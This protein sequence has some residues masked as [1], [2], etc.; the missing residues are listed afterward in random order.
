M[1]NH[2]AVRSERSGRRRR[3]ACAA[4]VGR[5][6]GKL[7]A[8]TCSAVHVITVTGKGE[9]ESVSLSLPTSEGGKRLEEGR[10]SNKSDSVHPFVRGRNSGKYR[11]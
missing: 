5:P 10:R 7:P 1:L 11:F 8:Y 2:A 4:A 9:S 6:A 3:Y